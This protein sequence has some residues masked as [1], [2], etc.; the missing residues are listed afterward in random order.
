MA[1]EALVFEALRR[2]LIGEAEARNLLGMSGEADAT[3]E[4]T[5]GG[6]VS[7]RVNPA[8]L[9]PEDPR[10][11]ARAALQ[12]LTFGGADEA[13]A[14]LRSTFNGEDYDA[15]L[16]DVRE[17]LDE[18]RGARPWEA[19]AYE[20]GGA[21]LPAIVAGIF[22]GGGATAAT[23]ARL[24]PTLARVAGI[25]AAEGGAY[26]FL[27]GEG[28]DAE[29]L[30][31]QALN[32][33]R[34]VP[35]GISAGIAGAGVG[36]GA[37]QLGR[38]TLGEFMEFARR[39]IGDRASRRVERE[40]TRVMQD[41]NLTLDEV[42]Q[43]IDDGEILAEMTP[44]MADVAR[45][46][47][48]RARGAATVLGE[49]YR[50]DG[51]PGRADTLRR[52]TMAYLQ[53]NLAGGGDDNVMRAVAMDDAARRAAESAEYKRV[54]AGAGEV[55]EDVV[56]ELQA[57][58][59][60]VPEA[61]ADVKRI[62][63]AR[64]GK[65][66]FFEIADD[67]TV[68][69]TRPPTLEDAEIVRRGIDAATNRQFASGAG[70]VGTEYRN[71]EGALRGALDNASDELRAVRAEW[72]KIESAAEAFKAGSSALSRHPDEV[73]IQFENATRLGEGAIKAFRRGVMSA[74]RRKAGTGGANSLPANIKS[75][76]KSIGQIVR[77]VFP[78]DE[79]PQLLRLA[80]RA[81]AS[82]S[83]AGKIMGGSP[84][85]ITEGRMAETSASIVPD[86]IDAA[87][88]GASGMFRLAGQT[89]KLLRPDLSS[90]EITRLAQMMVETDPN[91]L[92]R[93][94]TDTNPA[95]RL[96]VLGQNFLAGAQIPSEA[97]GAAVAQPG[98]N[99]LRQ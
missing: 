35:L 64:T 68:T 6:G 96:M 21:A 77:T 75:D 40:L 4:T 31:G 53:Q 54:F 19:L 11:R 41:N 65:T 94:M 98:V 34:G 20:A 59:A 46:Y 61:G 30:G 84:T 85:T 32:R 3:I 24:F 79:L 37:A 5:P 26:S 76:E 45:G 27:A 93:A 17:Q 47:R 88:G 42:L 66:P 80:N 16:K 89:L 15:A 22:T 8:V 63:R 50:P 99:M 71:V 81:A 48:A 2:G 86:V 10:E 44:E 33:V 29:T 14:W 62:Y 7:G 91:A 72:A 55:G 82:N 43:R 23:S 25:G 92:R 90:R 70:A 12:G 39:R 58:L 51:R 13:E 67:G 18:Y 87:A 78:E 95:Q 74:L 52:E 36:Y 73:A 49:T 60:R 1:D 83:A 38:A 57:A 9:E 28:G 56:A 97:V 69:F